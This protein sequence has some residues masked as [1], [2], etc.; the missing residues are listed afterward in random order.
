MVWQG[1]YRFRIDGWT[2]KEMTPGKVNVK[3]RDVK[4]SKLPRHRGRKLRS[5]PWPRWCDLG[6]ASCT[7][8]LVNIPGKHMGGLR[9][10][11]GNEV[12][13][14]SGDERERN[15]PLDFWTWIR[16]CSFASCALQR[17]AVIERGWLIVVENYLIKWG[18]RTNCENGCH[19][20]TA[21]ICSDL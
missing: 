13:G 2:E 12:W 18:R 20:V 10:E 7:Y 19:C 5:R 21:R 17:T 11:R 16:R 1:S 8:G 9:K 3:V 14:R 15:G 6:L 4:S